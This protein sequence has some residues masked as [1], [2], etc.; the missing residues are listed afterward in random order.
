MLASKCV[1][2]R[3]ED[4]EGAPVAGYTV[5]AA[6]S[7]RASNVLNEFHRMPSAQWDRMDRL[8]EELSDIVDDLKLLVSIL[9]RITQWLG[10]KACLM[11]TSLTTFRF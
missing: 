7:K 6:L 2:R 1:Q 3:I 9:R 8:I 4:S 11:K 5:L 10:S